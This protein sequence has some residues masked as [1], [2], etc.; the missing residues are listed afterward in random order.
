MSRRIIKT[1]RH[2]DLTTW[3][4]LILFGLAVLL[5]LYYVL[6]SGRIGSKSYQVRTLQEKIESLA[7]T[8]SSLMSKKLSLDTPVLIMD[9]AQSHNL[10]QAKNI[11]YIFEGKNVAL[12]R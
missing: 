7:E 9:F 6:V 11:S 4:N 10:V 8:N 1:I 3:T 5:L 12:Q 2:N